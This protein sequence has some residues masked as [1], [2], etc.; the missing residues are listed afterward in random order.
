M[1]V[2]LGNDTPSTIG[3]FII[4][5][6]GALSININNLK[7]YLRTSLTCQCNDF[8]NNNTAQVWAIYNEKQ[9]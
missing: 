3:T 2:Y 6:V 7:C 5:N 4:N 8:I 1:S 9:R